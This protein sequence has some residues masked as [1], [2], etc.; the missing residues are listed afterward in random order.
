MAFWRQ[1]NIARIASSWCT[2]DSLG[3]AGLLDALVQAY[4]NTT[5]DTI[6]NYMIRAWCIHTY[7]DRLVNVKK[8]DVHFSSIYM[9]VFLKI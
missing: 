7:Q 4:K 9:Y 1:M 6:P 3:G 2:S 8:V 5:K